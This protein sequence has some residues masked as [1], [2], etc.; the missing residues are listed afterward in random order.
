MSDSYEVVIV[1]YG[2]RE[3]TKGEVYLNYPVYGVADEP[4][5]MDYFFWV[6]RNEDRTVLVDTGFSQQGGAVRRRTFLIDPAAAYAAL[7][8]DPASRPTVVITHAH[9]D[10]I[11]NLGLFPASPLVIAQHEYD[12]WTGPHAGRTQFHHSVQDEEIDALAAAH[13]SGRVRTFTDRLE[14]APGI[15]LIEVGGHTPGQS[16]V[17]VRTADGP[18]LL[19][20]DAIHYYEEYERDRPFA[21]VADL[22]AMYE[23][24]DRIRAMVGS[25]EVR[26]LVS[27]HDPDTLARF[28]P[29]EGE[30]AGLAAT[31]GSRR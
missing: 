21:F 25:G 23:G 2:T 5:R 10:H 16:V 12:F 26:H 28:T 7:G 20:S 29:V 14:L 17:R 31:I 6:V 13:S 1:K 24:F 15:E 19:A 22:V 30:L 11:G 8:V 18:V 9:Y 27:G 4:I 3:A